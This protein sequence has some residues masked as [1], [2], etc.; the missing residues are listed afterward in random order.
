[1]IQK[2][3]QF[4]L[5]VI[6]SSCDSNNPE[7]VATNFMEFI[8]DGNCVEALQL[9]T[10]SA[11]EYVQGLMDSGCKKW[12][13]NNKEMHHR[14]VKSNFQYCIHYLIQ[15]EIIFH[16]IYLTKINHEWKIYDFQPKDDLVS[17]IGYNE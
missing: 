5:V 8:S 16:H 11:E 3:I 1:M 15:E 7:Y 2:S 17:C 9:T 12:E 6:F 10:G 14:K 4:F 13:G